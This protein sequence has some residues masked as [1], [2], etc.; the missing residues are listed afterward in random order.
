MENP[1]L[2]VMLFVDS[3]RR[4]FKDPAA[5]PVTG[6]G[7]E[8]ERVEVTTPLP[9]MPYAFV[10]ASMAADPLYHTVGANVA[11]WRRLRCRH[12][13]EYWAVSCA[14]IKD[15]MSPRDIP[16]ALNAPQRRVLSVLEAARRAAEP[17]RII[18]LK[19]R[20][21][22]G[23][24]LIQMYMA[25]I[26]LCHR[27][28]WNSVICAQVKDTAATIRA[29]YSKL[30]EN[31]PPDL[32]EA[33]SRPAFAPFERSINTR[34]IAGR[35]CRVTL[36]SGEKPD[37]MRGADYAMAH[38]SET[39]FWP[40]TRTHSPQD[41]IQ[42]VSGSIALLP[43]TLVAVESTA[44]GVG[45]YFHSEWIRSKNGIG[46]KTPVFVPWQEI[47]FNTLDAPDPAVVLASLDACEQRL[48]TMGCDTSQIWWRRR[49]KREFDSAERFNA[50][51]PGDDVE[52][53]S[54]SESAVFSPAK[55]EFLR[56]NCCEPLF[57]GEISADGNTFVTDAA[58]KLF[59]WRKPE[60]RMRYVVAVDV[61]GRSET[62]DWS[63]IA[64]MTHATTPELVAQWRGH[65]DH[66]L[67][68]AKALSVATF[69][70]K[71]L[72]VLESNTFET[73]NY[74]SSSDSNLFVLNRLARA[75]SNIYRRVSYDTASGRTTSKVGF[76]TNRS[77]K[78]MLVDG[79]IE[80]VRDDLYI[81]RDNLAC[82]ELHTYCRYP[83]GVFAAK[84]GYHDDILMT[85][86]M[87]LHII[88]TSPLPPE[89][90]GFGPKSKW[91]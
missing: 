78:A 4:L 45:D 69:Y 2:D 67:L 19:A 17:M 3:A 5:N 34:V 57:T 84:D 89:K 32:W 87:I 68:A 7:C 58:G 80:A 88:S 38:L 76:H 51:F 44:N 22:G 10:P 41:V 39:A 47:A 16:F 49:K 75:Y 37:S 90:I 81:E 1:G 59:V 64:V 24:T 71:A 23:S 35:D 61:G 86:A 25:W 56:R 54:A 52:A 85:R 12:D 18:L 42:S 36:G 14:V 77:T 48:W 55:V 26:Q 66:D 43:Y 8:G 13:F 29:M 28:N 50:E 46:D 20:Q 65:I 40:A 73:D 15:K 70:N 53:F 33:D 27:T 63:V 30:L 79:L 91:L 11:A 31:Y 21:W 60:A 83:N 82:N 6:Y 74:G 62:A 72:L 9:D